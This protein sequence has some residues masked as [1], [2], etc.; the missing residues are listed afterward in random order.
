MPGASKTELLTHCELTPR[1]YHG[2]RLAYVM[3]TNYRKRRP[4]YS[5]VGPNTEPKIGQLCDAFGV[6]YRH[7]LVRFETLKR[8]VEAAN[9]ESTVRLDYT[10]GAVVAG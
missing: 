2:A 1:S 6:F 10:Y 4:Y 3:D 5:L 7:L 9:R 8:S